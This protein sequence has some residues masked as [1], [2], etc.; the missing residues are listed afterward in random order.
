MPKFMLIIHSTPNAFQ[1]LSPEEIQRVVEK[2][3]GWVDKIKATGRYVVSDKLAD[4]GG[5]VVTMREGKL[6]VVNG[7][8]S[9]AKEVVGGYFT[10][11]AKNY[12]EAVELCADCPHL[13]YGRI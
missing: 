12:E 5:R 8:Y 1:G 6:S 9:E 3:R 4:E 7:P 10:L 2:Y 13:R 11:R